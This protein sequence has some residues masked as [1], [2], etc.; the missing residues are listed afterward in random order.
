MPSARASAYTESPARS[1]WKTRY[2]FAAADRGSRAKKTIAG[3]YDQPERGSAAK[4]APEN[5]CGFHP[6]SSKDLKLSPRNE[7]QG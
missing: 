3:P 1:R 6:G 7:Y 5:W 2:A 4:G